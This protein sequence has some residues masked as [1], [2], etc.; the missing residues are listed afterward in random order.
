VP[1]SHFDKY[2][3]KKTRETAVAQVADQPAKIKFRQW[4][5]RLFLKNKST[6]NNQMCIFFSPADK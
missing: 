6:R 2:F 5:N 1:V 4:L 3:G